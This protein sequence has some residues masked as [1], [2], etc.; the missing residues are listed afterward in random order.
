M[1]VY[2][3]IHLVNEWMSLGVQTGKLN[4]YLHGVIIKLY[5]T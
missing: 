4:K 3:F 2:I 5:I 1:S